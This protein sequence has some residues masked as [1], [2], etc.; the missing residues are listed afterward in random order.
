[1]TDPKT[2]SL[3]ALAALVAYELVIRP[4]LVDED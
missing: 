1:M 3:L 4:L 2:F